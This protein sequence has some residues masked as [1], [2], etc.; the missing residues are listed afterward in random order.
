VGRGNYLIDSYELTDTESR[1]SEQLYTN[2]VCHSEHIVGL[3]Q[4]EFAKL[5][6][7][8]N[9]NVPDM[10]QLLDPGKQLA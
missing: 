5:T 8:N 6:D 4:N 7:E 2:G 10:Q 9:C 3:H 1:S